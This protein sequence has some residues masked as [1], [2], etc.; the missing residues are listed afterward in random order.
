MRDTGPSSIARAFLFADV[1]GY[2][3]FVER[4]GDQA[5]A[6]L[7]RR[8]RDLVRAAV[9]EFQGAE[10]RTEGDSFYLA[11]RSPS[12]AIRCGLSI[13]EAAE[14]DLGGQRQLTIGIGIHAGETVQT[15]EGYVGSAVN[16]AAR[17]CAVAGAGELLVTDAVRAMTR[18]YLGVAFEPRGRRRLKG[19]AEPVALYRVHATAG[20]VNRSLRRRVTGL[21]GLRVPIVIGAIALAVFAVG[22]GIIGAVLLR[23]GAGSV[24]SAPS[25]PLGIASAPAVSDS[26]SSTL[27]P[28]TEY[29]TEAEQSLLNRLPRDI[30]H[31]TCDRA[32][33]TLR[34]TSM[35]FDGRI[36]TTA[37]VTCD[38]DGDEA[39]HEVTYWQAD[40]TVEAGGSAEHNWADEAFFA[41]VGINGIPRG[42][43]DATDSAYSSWTFGDVDGRFLCRPTS[44]GDIEILWTYDE[45]QIIARALRRDSDLGTLLDWWREHR[46][47]GAVD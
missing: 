23:E 36:P 3:A 46:L 33:A 29:P 42:D 16:I 18:T 30:R 13:L 45:E 21:A 24:D 20:T 4:H 1:R 40:T 39:P 31:S 17:V 12:A 43:C 10:I 37:A 34:S 35:Y 2:A 38:P 8:Y 44:E 28:S 15:D 7:L 5:G 14:S 6:D 41:V 27:A 9:A 32:E 22:A 11:F 47:I 26:A 19:I 25:A